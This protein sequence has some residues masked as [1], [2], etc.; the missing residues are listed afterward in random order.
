VTAVGA[1]FRIW[2]LLL[3]TAGWPVIA[4][5]GL[6]LP[7]TIVAIALVYQLVRAIDVV[8]ACPECAA[9]AAAPGGEWGSEK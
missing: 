3:A 2:L 4:E 5:A 8:P 7:A 9:R 1:G 6:T